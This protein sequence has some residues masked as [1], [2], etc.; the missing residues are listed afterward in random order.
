VLKALGNHEFDNNIEGLVP[1]LKNASFPIV[2]AN[3][4]DTEEPDMHGLVNKSVV[5]EVGGQRVGVVGYITKDTPE[6]SQ[7][8][9]LVSYLE[10]ANKYF[11]SRVP[12]KR[13]LHHYQNCQFTHR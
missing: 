5:L 13:Q 11:D 9:A 1:F 12:V 8:G 4:D 6:L 7:T 10:S 2:C 3:L